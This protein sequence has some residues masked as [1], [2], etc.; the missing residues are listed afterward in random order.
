MFVYIN[1]NLYCMRTKNRIRS[2]ALICLL[3]IGTLSAFSQNV[4]LKY[5]NTTI[6]QVLNSIKKQTGYS[7]VF[8]DQVLDVNRKVTIDVKNTSYAQA[9][10]QLL[11]GTDVTYVLKDKKIYFVKKSE[12]QKNNVNTTTQNRRKISGTVTDS[13]GEPVIGANVVVKGTTNGMITDTD[14]RFSI[15]NVAQGSTVQISYIGY[16]AQEI[17]IGNQSAL[18]IKLLEDTHA[19]DEVVV[20]GY[21]SQKKANLTGSVSTVKMDDVVGSRPII[22]AKEALQGT[23][24]GLFV[25]SGGNA[26]GASKSFR[27]RGSYSIGSGSTISPLVLI[28]NVEGD[29]DML[30]PEDIET[31]TVLKDAASA[32]IYGAR[33][34]GGVILV[35]TKRPQAKTSFSLN[36]NNN[37]AF[38]SAIN[39]PVQ[40][41]LE[42]YL[43]AYYDTYGD[44]YWTMGSPSV[45]KWKEYLAQYRNNPTSLD[46]VGD[47]CYKGP[48]GANYY[49]HEKDLVKD[50]LTTSSQMTHNLSATGGTDKIRY[51]LSASILDN[52]GVLVTNKDKYNRMTFSGFISA[53]VTP[54]LTQEA[55]FSYA[56]SKKTLPEGGL[57]Y[58][59]TRLISYY[60]EGLIP[61][62][63][64]GIGRDL[65]GQAPVDVIKYDNTSKTLIDRPRIFLKSILKPF[66]G[67]EGVFEYTFDRQ[68]YD[69]HFYSGIYE[70]TTIQGG[71][72][73]IPTTDYLTKSKNYTN[74]NT[75]NIY[76]TYTFD[77]GS[78]HHFKVM[79]GFNQESHYTESLSAYSYGQAVPEVPAMASGTSTISVT[80]SYNDYTVRGGF[81]R[82]NYNYLDRY[83]LEVN[84]R[85]DGS[86]KFPKSKRFGFFP[87]V[88]AG[89]QIAE[90]PFMQPMRDWLDQLKVRGSYGSIGNQNISSYSYTP[91]MSINNKYNGW[92]SNSTYVT[93]ITSIPALVRSNFTWEKVYTLDF[94]LDFSFLRS[95]LS[96]TFDWYRR[97]TKGMLAPGVELPS[98]VGASAPYQNTA[99][100]RTNG[101]EFA[102]NWQD[103]IGKFG[104]RIGFNLT[105]YQSHI[106]KYDSNN[107]YLLS[108]Y[109]KGEKLG[110]IWGYIADGY[111][112]VNDFE[113]TSTWKLKDGIT[114]INGINPRPGDVKFKNL[115]DDENST[116]VIT[117]GN[118][119]KDNPGD[120]KIIGNSQP[121]WLYGINLGINYAGFDLS[122]F[123]QGVGKRDSWVANNIMFPLYNDP[124]FISLYKGTE[125]YWKPVDADNGDYT[126]QNPNAKYPR[127]YGSYGN[128]GSNY[129]TSDKYLSNTAYLRI[130]NVSLSYN[131][132]K[133]WVNKLTMQSLKAFVSVENLATF[134]PLRKGIDPETLGWNYPLFRTVSFG[135]NLT[136]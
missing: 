21:G 30:N 115:M 106:T 22:S 25:G 47:G 107:S 5:E 48:D 72:Q 23:V 112:T 39:L 93:A 31:I 46:V 11:A 76:G 110:E 10:E 84:G 135:L 78:D 111:Y 120:R 19:L 64:S 34:A 53:D 73:K 129:R 71:D 61:A 13:K 103:R 95:R 99:D 17:R 36:Y 117:S 8:S 104:Y 54:W 92:L 60:P 133:A 59:T 56:H 44:Q 69:Y 125:D 119:T 113:S 86:S 15:E 40:S 65:P 62:S 6:E 85:Y 35:T 90:E 126:A 2:L 136:F 88:S 20:V 98:V 75:F 24:P 37:F 67:F 58:Y 66:K 134:T 80:D 12:P 1:S 123:M 118:G 33:A 74:N 131:V 97:D 7:L 94:G 55:T 101:W 27:I 45:T 91:T 77:L 82:F 114:T 29:V 121:R 14:G 89:W 70:Y 38:E 18:N 108:N 87:S 52:D 105:D 41:S 79:G 57:D 4:T 102:V 68:D 63:I 43:T 50:M 32:A 96:G 28:D 130:K 49:L 116:N 26:P 132:P 122:V 127:I 100:M 81:F 51:R 128:A 9:L 109:Y 124:K 3:L 42:D 16:I 83:L